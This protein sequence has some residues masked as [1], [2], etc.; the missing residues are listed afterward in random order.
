MM[1]KTYVPAYR[2]LRSLSNKQFIIYSL[3]WSPC[4]YF[5]HLYHL[6]L[7]ARLLKST[8]TTI[9]PTI[10]ITIPTSTTRR[11]FQLLLIQF[12]NNKNNN[13]ALLKNF[14]TINI[15]LV[16]P[17]NANFFLNNEGYSLKA[18]YMSKWKIATLLQ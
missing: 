4:R 8:T 9:L 18:I 13:I 1:I 12:Y 5:D 7:E 6:T 11:I 2:L 16:L 15:R 17:K 3:L 14:N 10:S